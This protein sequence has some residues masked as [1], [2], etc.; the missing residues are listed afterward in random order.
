MPELP[1]NSDIEHLSLRGITEIFQENWH[2]PVHIY[3]VTKV[4]EKFEKFFSNYLP[5]ASYLAYY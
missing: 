3:C 4:T 5:F 2:A 1:D